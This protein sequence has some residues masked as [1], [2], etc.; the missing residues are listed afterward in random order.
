ML[1][2]NLL[3]SSFGQYTNVYCMGKKTQKKEDS[4]KDDNKEGGIHDNNQKQLYALYYD[5]FSDS[6][7][8]IDSELKKTMQ[9]ATNQTETKSVNLKDPS[10]RAEF[11]QTRA[12]SEGTKSQKQLTTL[13]FIFNGDSKVQKANEDLNTNKNKHQGEKTIKNPDEDSQGGFQNT[14]KQPYQFCYS[15]SEKCR[16][17]YCQKNDLLKRRNELPRQKIKL[18]EQQNKLPRQKIKLLEQQNKLLEQQNDFLKQK[19]KLLGLR[20]ELPRQKI[21]LLEQQNKLPRQKI[22]F[23]SENELLEQQNELLEQKNE[24]KKAKS[25]KKLLRMFR[26]ILKNMMIACLV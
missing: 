17:F 8:S 23:T 15:D 20:N 26:T 7:D 1:I 6:I 9:F 14:S 12:Y 11:K 10:N 21:K 16:S 2:K 13:S 3:G 5:G 22:K 18:L 4:T 25:R 24:L 19:I